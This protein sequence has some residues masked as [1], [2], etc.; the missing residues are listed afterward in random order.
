MNTIHPNTIRKMIAT[1]RLKTFADD[2]WARTAKTT[3]NPK[4]REEAIT[5]GGSTALNS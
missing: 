3:A 5:L 1:I 2:H 4:I